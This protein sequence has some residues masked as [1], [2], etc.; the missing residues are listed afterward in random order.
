MLLYLRHK[1]R[2]FI[3]FFLPVRSYVLECKI[4][5]KELI[6]RL[7]EIINVDKM[8]FLFPTSTEKPYSGKFG[9]NKFIA[10][11]S[12]KT[13]SQ[14]QIKARGDFYILN[15]KIYLRLILSNPFSIMNIIVI[16]VL[17]FSMLIFS[18]WLFDFW[19]WNILIWLIP[20][21][22]TYVFTNLSFQ[23][24]Y[25]KEKQRFFKLTNSRRLSDKE[26]DKMGI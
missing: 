1:Y 25:R 6:E 18:V 16:G 7:H 24:S 11:K 2:K 4:S 23:S 20:I 3:L 9:I 13:T 5:E 26:I 14:R 17:Y 19:L 15:Q 8:Y 10:I 22:I 12:N 21:F